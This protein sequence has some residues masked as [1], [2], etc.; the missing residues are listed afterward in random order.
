MLSKSVL[1]VES[2][3]RLIDNVVIKFEFAVDATSFC[4]ANFRNFKYTFFLLPYI[5]FIYVTFSVCKNIKSYLIIYLNVEVSL[6]LSL[7]TSV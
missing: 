5:R 3:P 1:P 7:K 6:L 4:L 2:W